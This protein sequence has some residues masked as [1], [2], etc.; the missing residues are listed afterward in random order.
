[1][2]RWPE[3]W[4]NSLNSCFLMN[5]WEPYAT[6]V[7]SSRLQEV[8]RSIEEAAMDLG[9]TPFKAFFQITLPGIAPALVAGWLLSFTLCLKK[10]Y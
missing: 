1:M 2:S 4:R 7:I 6:V 10:Q 3:A 5:L 9:A 8:D